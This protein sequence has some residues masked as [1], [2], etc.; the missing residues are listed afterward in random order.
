M[1]GN[2]SKVITSGR[3][4]SVYYGPSSNDC[5]ASSC[6]HD[7]HRHHHPQPSQCPHC[8]HQDFRLTNGMPIH[9]DP[10]KEVQKDIVLEPNL[11]KECGTI[12]GIIK[13]K[14]G[15]PVE[16]ALVKVFDTHH[17]PVTHVFTN[18][19]GQFLLCL[20]PGDYILKAVR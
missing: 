10:G 17:H 15:R 16:N 13:D 11:F 3:D 7:S 5:Q 19:E 9:L 4:G 6:H 2:V 8:D 14:H 20:S 12:S 18:E 1:N